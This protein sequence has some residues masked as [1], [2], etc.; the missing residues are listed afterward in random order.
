MF[1]FAKKGVCLLRSVC[2]CMG[3]SKVE[4]ATKH[5]WVDNVSCIDCVLVYCLNCSEKS[6]LDRGPLT[7]NDFHFQISKVFA[8]WAHD[9][10]QSPMYSRVEQKWH[11]GSIP[12]FWW[13]FYF[14]DLKISKQVLVLAFESRLVLEAESM[15]DSCNFLL[16]IQP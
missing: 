6:S 1:I 16:F 2:L 8:N 7:T 3:S 10:G 14:A 9:S 12:W 11:D 4:L 15:V 5:Y 13:L